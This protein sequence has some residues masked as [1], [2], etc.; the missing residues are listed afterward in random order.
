MWAAL[1]LADS[2]TLLSNWP[3]AR[4]VLDQVRRIESQPGRRFPIE[5]LHCQLAVAALDF[6][7]GNAQLEA[8]DAILKGYQQLGV[9]WPVEY[10]GNLVATGKAAEPKRM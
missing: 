7:E 2:Y 6:L 9:G 5:T 3:Q 1:G 4:E 8:F 10:V